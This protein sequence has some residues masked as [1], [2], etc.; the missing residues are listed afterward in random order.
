[1][2]PGLSENKNTG[3]ANTLGETNAQFLGLEIQANTS[4]MHRG[5]GHCWS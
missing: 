5:D 2:K 1:M 3:L 4:V